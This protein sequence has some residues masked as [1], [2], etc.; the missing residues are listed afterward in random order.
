MKVRLEIKCR[1]IATMEIPE[2]KVAAVEALGDYCE[3]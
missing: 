3:R 1:G 2:D